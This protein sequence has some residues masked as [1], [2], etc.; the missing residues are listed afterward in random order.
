[1]EH[2][3]ASLERKV[4]AMPAYYPT[5][6]GGGAAFSRRKEKQENRREHRLEEDLVQG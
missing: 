5:P 3:K 4:G 2:G 1:M 6:R